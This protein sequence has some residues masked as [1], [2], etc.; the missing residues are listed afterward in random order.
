MANLRTSGVFSLG[1]LGGDRVGAVPTFPTGSDFKISNGTV[2]GAT[3]NGSGPTGS[4]Y[5][6]YWDTSSGSNYFSWTPSNASLPTA[7]TVIVDFETTNTNAYKMLASFDISH[8]SQRASFH[9]NNAGEISWYDGAVKSFGLPYSANTRYVA[10]AVYNGTTITGYLVDTASGTTITAADIT[11]AKGTSQVSPSYT[12]A[13][14][15]TSTIGRSANAAAEWLSGQVY[16]GAYW[17]SALTEAQLVDAVNNIRG[18]AAVA[19]ATRPTRRWGGMT[20]RS[21][22]ETGAATG[23]PHWNNVTLLLDGTSAT[24]DAANQS[25][26]STYGTVNANQGSAGAKWANTYY[27]DLP[28][29]GHVNVTLP[30]G[31]GLGRSGTPFTIEGWVRFDVL[32][33]DG[34]FQ[35]LSNP[36]SSSYQLPGD[37]LGLMVTG[38]NWK[39]YKAAGSANSGLGSVSTGT[40]Y[41]V[42]LT[43][44]GTTLRWY[45]D[46][47]QIEDYPVA[48]ATGIPAG[49]FPYL[50]IGGY[51]SLSYPMDGRIQDFRVTDGVARYTGSGTQTIPSGPLPQGAAV[52]ASTNVPTTGVLTLAEDYQSKL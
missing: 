46:G 13:W 12:T 44:D 41:H 26:V 25:T 43:S 48:S 11:A 3:Y 10:I 52:A 39:V 32:G 16:G 30:T 7:F 49:G 17:P 20:G 27:I 15:S 4:G 36:L 1:A 24:A 23:D 42:A 40:Y 51:F 18:N 31:K 38:S 19:A 50:A 6:S 35:L 5:S 45:V 33:D 37:S 22:V 14:N 34:I 2:T 29:S 21:L 9:A 47:N 8:P 28:N